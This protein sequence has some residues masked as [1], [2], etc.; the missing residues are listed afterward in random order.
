MVL[1]GNKMDLE[2]DRQVTKQMAMDFAVGDLGLDEH[3]A[4]FESNKL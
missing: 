3:L 1:L 2:E 4:H